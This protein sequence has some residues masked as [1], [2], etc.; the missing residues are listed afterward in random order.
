[1]AFLSRVG[2]CTPTSNVVD[3]KYIK[4]LRMMMMMMMMHA[5]AVLTLVLGGEN[6]PSVGLFIEEWNSLKFLLCRGVFLPL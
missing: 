6:S 3:S 1:M 5:Y 4:L 2:V